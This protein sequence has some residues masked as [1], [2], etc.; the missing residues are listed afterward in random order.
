V[1][2]YPHKNFPSARRRLEGTLL[3][4]VSVDTLCSK[5]WG[6]VDAKYSGFIHWAHSV[7]NA[8]L[9]L[10]CRAACRLKPNAV[11]QML[12]A[13]CSIALLLPLRCFVIC[14]KPLLMVHFG[15]RCSDRCP[16]CGA[17]RSGFSAG[18]FSSNA[19]CGVRGVP[20]TSHHMAAT[21]GV[22]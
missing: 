12:C 15:S 4:R 13:M 1:Y 7:R 18:L 20:V 19:M 5:R 21:W 2:F 9:A 6:G 8:L 17:H 11:R 3:H 10:I 14:P 16:C 22:R